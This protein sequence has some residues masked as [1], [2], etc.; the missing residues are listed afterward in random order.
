MGDEMPRC[1]VSL[2][3]LLA[4]MLCGP[5]SAYGGPAPIPYLGGEDACGRNCLYVALRSL[6]A[7]PA[8]LAE[9]EERIGRPPVGGYHLKRLKEGAETYGMH[10]LG[11]RTSLDN[12]ARRPRPF[13]CIAHYTSGHFVLVTEI[14]AQGRGVRVIDPPN[15]AVDLPQETFETLWSGN[16]LLISP[17][18]L[19]AEEK[20]PRDFPWRSVLVGLGTLLG[21]GALGLLWHRFRWTAAG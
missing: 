15:T 7:E 12:L 10:T 2:P 5:L 18:P 13:A 3:T 17:V 1:G 9:I 6:G 4:A 14:V 11:V 16:A 19:I 8:S 20:L 21:F